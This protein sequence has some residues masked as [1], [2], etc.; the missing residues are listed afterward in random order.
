[1]NGMLISG[2]IL[3]LGIWNFNNFDNTIVS[4]LYKIEITNDNEDKSTTE[5]KQGAMSNISDF[6]FSKIPEKL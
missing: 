4:S 5:L 3:F 1:M 6:C 2:A